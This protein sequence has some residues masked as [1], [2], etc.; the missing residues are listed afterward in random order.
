MTMASKTAD[1]FAKTVSDDCG[2]L[3]SVGV[4]GKRA[5]IDPATITL[6]ITQIVLPLA[7]ALIERCRARREQQDSPQQQIAK[8]HADA[9]ARSKNIDTLA[10]KILAECRTRRTAEIRK[11]KSTGL[12]A[13]IGRYEM[14]S[15]SAYRLADKMHSRFATM[16]P[17]DAEA[18]CGEYGVT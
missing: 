15:D 7:Q 14:D 16:R 13:D 11:A 1:K 18:L 10:R 12:P 17:S 8:A 3:V 5:G 6:L 2:T 4:D 9:N